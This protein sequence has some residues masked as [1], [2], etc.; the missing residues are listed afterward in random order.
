MHTSLAH[1]FLNRGCSMPPKP[2]SVIFG[3][4]RGE[5]CVNDGQGRNLQ[6]SF[7]K[8]KA[9]RFE[10]PLIWTESAHLVVPKV[11]PFMSSKTQQS[12]F[13]LTSAFFIV[14]TGLCQSD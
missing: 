6:C 10:K 12:I 13:V 2:I 5:R 7:G 8:T 11:S 3:V 9:G 1:F 14:F 4:D